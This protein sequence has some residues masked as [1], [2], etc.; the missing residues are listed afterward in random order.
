MKLMRLSFIVLVV[1]TLMEIC[2]RTDLIAQQSKREIR[3]QINRGG[4]NIPGLSQGRVVRGR[5]R[6]ENAEPKYRTVYVTTLEPTA[7][8][9]DAVSFYSIL[10]DS[11]LLVTPTH[12]AVRSIL[13]FDIDNHVFCYGIRSVGAFY[14][15]KSKRGGY[16]GEY[17][18]LY[19]DDDGDGRFERLEDAGDPV[20]LL[21]PELPAW[22]LGLK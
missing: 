11:T 18:L 15:R 8:V 21:T 9:I 10:D 17:T 12:L 14:D 19:Y 2:A 16:G 13:R 3:N 20:R 4:W 7:E 22:V 5:T 6:L 1:I